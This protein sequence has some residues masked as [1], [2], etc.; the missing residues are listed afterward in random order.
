MG[1]FIY[2]MVPQ[3]MVG[4]KLIPLNSFKQAYPHLYERYTKKYFK[5]PQRTKLLQ[6]QVPKLNCLW[7]DVLHFLP[8]HPYFIYNAITSL[9][10]EMKADVPFYKIPIQNLKTNNNAIY[11]YSKEN[12]RGPAEDINEDEIRIIEMDEYK[13]MTEIPLA[14]IEYYTMEKERGK[15]FG[16]FPFI[17][18]L[19]SLGEVA[20]NGVEIIQWNKP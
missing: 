20:V 12:Y 17:P 15:E 10:L 8:L 6:R 1:N 9:G 7:N 18:H 5:D 13:E 11:L 16:M 14:T 4:D 2:H 19:L 3:E